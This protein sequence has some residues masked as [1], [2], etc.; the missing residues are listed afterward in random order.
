[1]FLRL[2][3]NEHQDLV[4]AAGRAGLTPTGYAAQ[5]ALAAARGS[6]PPGSVLLREA[7]AE[8]MTARTQVCRF[9]T[10]VNQAVAALHTVGSP[11]LWLAEAVQVTTRATGRLTRPL[12]CCPGDWRDRQGA[13]GGPGQRPAALPVRAGPGR[14]NEHFDPHLVAAW[15]DLAALEPE[16]AV[17]GRRDFRHLTGL[18]DQPLAAAGVTDRTRTVWH[19]SLRTAPG[20]RWLT[21]TE[22]DELC[23][24]VLARTG[25]AAPDDDGGCRWVAVRHAD[26][27]VHLVVT[28][29]RQDGR[30]ATVSN[31]FYRVGEACRAAEQRYGL[32]VTAARDRAAARRPT[33]AEQER[34]VR[35]GR[36][37]PARTRLRREVRTAAAAACGVEDFLGRLPGAG[38]LV[39]E[40]TSERAPRELT[41]YA[42]ARPGDRNRA[43][44]PVWYGGGKLAADLSLPRLTRRWPTGSRPDD[45]VRLSPEQRRAAWQQAAAAAARA[46]EDLRAQAGIDRRPEP[47]WLTPRDRSCT[48][49]RG[50]PRATAAAR[51]RP[52]RRPTTGPAGSRTAGCRQ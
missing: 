30:R 14:A 13:A 3:T 52:S 2:S 35:A 47:T 7:L 28:L 42:V 11:P 5:A 27:H 10:N 36:L 25:L 9:A 48:S 20:D 8:V 31:D 4:A 23:Q 39:K 43:G 32:R 46:A 49:P 33:R 44:L 19:C 15:D 34:A 1:V 37:E 29:A 50:W 41:G 12:G 17:G 6:Q 38:L 24:D 51:L 21:D 16:R 22:W 40:R 45:T 18:L 26:D